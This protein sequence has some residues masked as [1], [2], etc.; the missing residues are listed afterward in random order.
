M[1]WGIEADE[2]SSYSNHRGEAG[3]YHL[4]R[5]LH[6]MRFQDVA[7]AQCFMRTLMGTP[8]IPDITVTTVFRKRTIQGTYGCHGIRIRPHLRVGTLVHELAHHVQHN[9]PGGYASRAHGRD[10][11]MALRDLATEARELMGLPEVMPPRKPRLRRD[12]QVA[13]KGTDPQQTGT[14]VRP[15]GEGW[16]LLRSGGEQIR[17]HRDTLERCAKASWEEGSRW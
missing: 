10:F 15:L 11:K 5:E 6:Q 14:L 13:I 17:A 16:W 9:M 3:L 7:A 12:T 8:D 4:T 1:A 2:H